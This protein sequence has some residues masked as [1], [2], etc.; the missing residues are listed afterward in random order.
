MPNHVENIITLKGD[1]KRIREMLEAI[2]NDD[3]GL[4]T[5]D[6]NKIIPMPNSLN[7]EAGSRTDRGLKAYSDFID[8]YVFGRNAE[9][10]LNAIQNIPKESED[11]FL[12]QRTDVTIDEWELGK[13]AWNNIQN[14]GAPTWYEWSINNWGTKWNLPLMQ[15]QSRKQLILLFLKLSIVR[16]LKLQYTQIL[17]MKVRR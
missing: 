16:V 14:Y 15:V 12:K 7:I 11:V 9:D 13:T 8:V 5:L 1:E 4:G 2:K 3:F 10:A 17:M 6:F